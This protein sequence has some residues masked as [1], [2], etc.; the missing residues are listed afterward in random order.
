MRQLLILNYYP[1][2]NLLL[3]THVSLEATL[4]LTFNRKTSRSAHKLLEN[5]LKMKCKEVMNINHWLIKKPSIVF[6]VA[7]TK[8]REYLMQSELLAIYKGY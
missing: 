1:L 7:N 6:K 2:K 3:N 8:E 4:P 5:F